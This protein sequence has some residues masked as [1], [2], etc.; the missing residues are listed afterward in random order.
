HVPT[1][2]ALNGDFSVLEAAQSAGGCLSA[3]RVLKDPANNNNPFPNNQIPV[4]R[5]DPAALKLVK[6]Y[7]PSSSDPCGLTLYGQPANN[8]DDQIIGRVDYVR[9][10]KH[11]IFGRFFV[12]NY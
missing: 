3:A 9:S 8:P 2:A 1:A 11:Q 12:Y 6:T 10:D 7:I 4:S 5:F